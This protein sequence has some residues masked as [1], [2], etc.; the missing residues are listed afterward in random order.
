MT[1]QASQGLPTQRRE[2]SV[3]SIRPWENHIVSYQCSCS[4]QP[5]DCLCPWREQ[6]WDILVTFLNEDI[7]FG[8]RQPSGP[9]YSDMM[10]KD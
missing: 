2:P 9:L 4:E 1:S 5:R 3:Q 8:G 6:P 10:L 7:A